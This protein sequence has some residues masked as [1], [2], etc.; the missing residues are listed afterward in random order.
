MLRNRRSTKGQGL[1]RKEGPP[2][3][4]ILSQNVVL[5]RFTLSLSFERKTSCSGR[6]FNESHPASS[7]LSMKDTLILLS[8]SVQ[9]KPSCFCRAFN[10]R[11]VDKYF[12]G[13]TNS[14][15]QSQRKKQNSAKQDGCVEACSASEMLFSK[16]ET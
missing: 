4:A 16:S 8:Y 2:T 6:A 3:Y 12:L 11:A 10:I 9:L 5:S 13:E 7:E 15:M 14:K 1:L